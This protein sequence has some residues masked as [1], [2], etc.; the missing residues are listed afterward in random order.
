MRFLTAIFLASAVAV[1]A[2]AWATPARETPRVAEQTTFTNMPVQ[3]PVTPSAAVLRTILAA[4]PA[5]EAFA[6]LDDSQRA[7][8][9]QLFQAGE[10][11]LSQSGQMDLVVVGLGP[12]R[13]ADTTWFW[14]VASADKEPQLV[15]FS[16]GDSLELLNSKSHG[17][18]DIRTA[19]SSPTETET[20]IYNFDGSEYQMR[21]ADNFRIPANP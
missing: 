10:V 13:G 18:K 14:V 1:V 19:W 21:R 5:R 3:D 15:L 12:M 20:T 16:G 8:P 6:A 11:H 9:G 4:H 2:M 17:Y 7:N